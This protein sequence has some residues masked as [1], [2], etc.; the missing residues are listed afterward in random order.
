MSGERGAVSG[1]GGVR[2]DKPRADDRSV[3]RVT[4]ALAFVF[5][6]TVL[7]V[8]VV[9]FG[10]SPASAP[11]PLADTIASTYTTPALAPFPLSTKDL[12]QQC[13]VYYSPDVKRPMKGH[14]LGMYL[15][16]GMDDEEE[17]AAWRQYGLEE[18]DTG[19]CERTLTYLLDGD[20]GVSSLR[21]QMPCCRLLT[22]SRCSSSFI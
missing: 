7:F 4:I 3:S 1:S 15:L 22:H 11:S 9:F 12:Y 20:F 13:H 18:V 5:A 17:Q 6:I 14:G 2:A 10:T 19:V 16:E 8:I 21:T